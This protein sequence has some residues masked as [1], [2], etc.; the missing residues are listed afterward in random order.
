MGCRRERGDGT[1]GIAAPQGPASLGRLASPFRGSGGR[2]AAS[3]SGRRSRAGPR[4][5]ASARLQRWCLRRFA[6]WLRPGP[7]LCHRPCRWVV[8]GHANCAA[9]TPFLRHRGL[10]RLAARGLGRRGEHWRAPG[11]GLGRRRLGPGHR[12][13]ARHGTLPAQCP[14]GRG[15]RLGRPRRFCLGRRQRQRAPEF[16][17]AVLRRC[18][19]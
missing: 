19:L 8:V 17:P 12:Y 5:R 6:S 11:A 13:L 9:Q 15:W 16:L 7:W 1:V 4:R 10:D 18:S 2:R 14:R 3:R